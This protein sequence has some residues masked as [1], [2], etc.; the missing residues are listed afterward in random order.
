MGRERE[1]FL[2]FKKFFREKENDVDQKLSSQPGVGVHARNPSTWEAETRR[3]TG[4]KTA[5]ASSET[6]INLARTCFKMKA[7]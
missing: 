3:I 7:K 5:S 4:S 2:K 6:L 1:R